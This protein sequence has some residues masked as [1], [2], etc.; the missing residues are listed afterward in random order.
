MKGA[1]ASLTRGVDIEIEIPLFR[2]GSQPSAATLL[3]MCRGVQ[4][5]ARYVVGDHR[6]RGGTT[7]EA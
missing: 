4:S 7:V 3:P 5:S 1:E 2:H 6:R